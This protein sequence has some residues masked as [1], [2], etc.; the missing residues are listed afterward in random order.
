[1]IWLY[2]IGWTA[3]SLGICALAVELSPI[4]PNSPLDSRLSDNSG[5]DAAEWLGIGGEGF[6]PTH[7]GY[8]E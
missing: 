3:L 8:E 7:F 1:M 5:D 4:I 6:V 2:A